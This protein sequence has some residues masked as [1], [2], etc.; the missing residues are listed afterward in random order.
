VS[1]NQ[2]PTKR[3]SLGEYLRNERERAGWSLRQFATMVGIHYSYLS[4]LENGETAN[5]AAELLQRMAEVLEIDAAEL[6]AYIG[7]KPSRLPEPRIYFRHMY[8]LTP[9][10]AEQAAKLMEQEFRSRKK[11]T[12]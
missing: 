11:P 3:P 6:L 8:G 7:V 9:E 12:N 4:R 10:Q 1:E 5:P 2:H